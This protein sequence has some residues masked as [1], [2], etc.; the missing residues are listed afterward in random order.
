MLW[1]GQGRDTFVFVAMGGQDDVADLQHG[2]DQLDLGAFGFQS[3]GEVLDAA[4]RSGRNVVIEL[5]ADTSVTVLDTSIA[6]FH[7]GDFI[8]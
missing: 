2:R 8:L 4:S 3:L 7:A 6:S 1:G 5:D